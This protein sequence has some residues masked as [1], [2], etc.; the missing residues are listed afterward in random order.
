MNELQSAIQQR[1]NDH[2]GKASLHASKLSLVWRDS[3]LSYRSMSR[4]LNAWFP[5]TLF[6]DKSVVGAYCPWVNLPDDAYWTEGLVRNL[7][8]CCIA[9]FEHRQCS[10]RESLIRS[11]KLYLWAYGGH[12]AEDWGTVRSD[13]ICVSKARERISQIAIGDQ[14]MAG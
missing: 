9:T 7:V 2:I 14:G 3:G 10:E 13:A 8:L 11:V 1:I 12:R 4:L 6:N 5:H